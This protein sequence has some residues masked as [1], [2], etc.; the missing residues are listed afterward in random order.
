MTPGEVV[1]RHG[2]RELAFGGGKEELKMVGYGR[3]EEVVLARALIESVRY[4]AQISLN[5]KGNCS[6][7]VFEEFGGFR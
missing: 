1:M 2:P 5:N 3:N 4:S 7:P 6:V